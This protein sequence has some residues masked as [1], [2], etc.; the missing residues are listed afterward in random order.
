MEST[1]PLTSTTS[2]G[3]SFV[4]LS[5]ALAPWPENKL[6]AGPAITNAIPHTMRLF[7]PTLNGL[8]FFM[9]PHHFFTAQRVLI[10]AGKGGV[11]KS[12]L[13]TSLAYLSARSGMR[14]LLVSLDAP[15]TPIP[16][17]D[18]LEQITVSPGRALADYLA[19]K[20]LGLLSRQLAKS[21]IMELVATTAPGLDDLL[22]LGRI[23]AFEQELRADVIIVDGP[24]AGHALD[25]VRAPAQ[26]KRAIGNGPISSQADEVIAM[27]ADGT[28]CKVMLVT[29]PAITPVTETCEA[30]EE[31]RDQAGVALAP[32]VVNKY[33]VLVPTIDTTSLSPNSRDALQY[34]AQRGVAQTDALGVLSDSLELPQLV[35]KRH[36]LTGEELV[37]ALAEDLEEAI[38]AMP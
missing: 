7:A 14:T 19:T 22:V 9:E 21:G 36:R 12:T 26:L 6:R 37:V 28:R 20:G 3:A 32:I 27:F 31:L 30:A 24:A 35:T 34:L 10:V 18:L 25:L 5:A 29:T 33:E 4:E 23:K 15:S 8:S 2:T 16:P 38:K 1:K 13:A 11:G 17:H